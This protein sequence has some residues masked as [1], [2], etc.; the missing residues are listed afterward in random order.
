[1][2]LPTANSLISNVPAVELRNK[3]KGTREN[4]CLYDYLSL[5]D[6]SERFLAVMKI[7]DTVDTA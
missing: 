3:H 6:F 2:S 4:G 1:M 5:P 7:V